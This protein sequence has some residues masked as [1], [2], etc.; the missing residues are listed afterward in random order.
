MSLLSVSF[1][2]AFEQALHL[3]QSREVTREPPTK[4]DSSPLSRVFS[5]F[6][7]HKLESLLSGDKYFD[8]VQLVLQTVAD[9]KEKQRG[10][11]G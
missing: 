2:L 8:D 6:S 1:I 3:K 4:G 9:L 5:L 10:Y 7:R 11:L